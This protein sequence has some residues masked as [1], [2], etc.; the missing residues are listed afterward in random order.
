MTW[1][2]KAT[3]QLLCHAFGALQ[4]SPNLYVNLIRN[5]EFNNCKATP[6]VTDTV[7]L[8]REWTTFKSGRGE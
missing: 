5:R 4:I 8:R 3:F 2:S 7:L 6:T 1:V